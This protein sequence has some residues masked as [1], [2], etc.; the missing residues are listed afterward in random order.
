MAGRHPARKLVIDPGI[1]YSSY[2]G[3]NFAEAA[4]DVTLDAGG[5]VYIT[6]YTD[7]VNFP[8]VLGSFDV[9]S[10]GDFDVFVW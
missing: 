10:N 8:T 9:S 2:F 7:S 6:G 5:N 1:L 3:G 4:Q